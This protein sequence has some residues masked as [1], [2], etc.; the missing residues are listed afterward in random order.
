MVPY[1]DFFWPEIYRP[2][3][4][5]CPNHKRKFPVY[6]NILTIFSRLY[7]YIIQSPIDLRQR[8]Y[9]YKCEDVIYNKHTQ[10]W[11]TNNDNKRQNQYKTKQQDSL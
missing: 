7:V 5:N 8:A 3:A 1:P 4:K 11:K 2:A 6:W 9:Q 10:K